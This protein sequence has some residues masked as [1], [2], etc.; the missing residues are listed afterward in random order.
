MERA[1]WWEV[2]VT[3]EIISSHFLKSVLAAYFSEPKPGNSPRRCSPLD[4]CPSWFVNLFVDLKSIPKGPSLPPFLI[5]Y[6]ELVALLNPCFYYYNHLSGLA[7]GEVHLVPCITR[8]HDRWRS[9]RSIIGW[10][11]TREC[12]GAAGSESASGTCPP[13]QYKVSIWLGK[14]REM[15]LLGRYCL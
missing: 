12:Q 14:V 5:S 6:Y 9:A 7:V 1:M 8:S 10:E 3:H 15:A 4:F 13:G 11:E 2:Q